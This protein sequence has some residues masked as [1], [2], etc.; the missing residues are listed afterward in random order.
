MAN[1][2]NT[3]LIKRYASRRLYNTNTSDYVTLDEVAELIRS[4]NEVKIVDRKTG[5]D[6]TRQYLLQIITEQETR[7]ENVL[8]INVLMDLVRSYSDQTESMIP[9][10]LSQS[11]EMLKNQQSMA[12][13]NIQKHLPEGLD[14]IPSFGI[15]TDWQKKQSDLLNSMMS[16]WVPGFGATEEPEEQEP[17]APASGEV[18]EIKRQLAELQKKMSKL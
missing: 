7:G 1:N 6:L 15:P 5:D 3:I 9:S 14:Q 18:E 8:P 12:M 4:G 16:A 11:Y 17:E 2:D 10:F 13:E